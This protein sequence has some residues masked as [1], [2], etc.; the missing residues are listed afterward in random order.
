MAYTE[1][2]MLMLSG[3]QHFAFCPRQ[4]GLIHI[5]QA[6]ADNHFT[7]EGQILHERVDD[8][9]Y[10]T[11]SENALVLRA[12]K[13]QSPSL[14]VYGVCDALELKKSDG[15]DDGIKLP[16]YDGY[17][18]L[19]P[20]EYKRGKSKPT[21][22]D[23]LQLVAQAICLEEEFDCH[24]DF[25]YIYYGEERHRTKVMFDDKLRFHCQQVCYQMHEVFSM[26]KT[27]APT[28]TPACK[29]CSLKELCMPELAKKQTVNKYLKSIFDETIT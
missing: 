22:V 4:W 5:E 15:Q 28:V 13:V 9:F 1:D 20:V 24:I 26:G 6:W 25:G 21:P 18:S 27:P 8:P 16:K 7:V 14:G 23:E 17:W 19:Y 2:E 3:I 12:Y 29:S 10:R 11:K